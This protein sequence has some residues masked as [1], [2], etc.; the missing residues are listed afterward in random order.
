MVSVHEDQRQSRTVES[1]TTGFRTASLMVC[2]M[3][4]Y[5]AGWIAWSTP[6]RS[7]SSAQC[8]EA[9]SWTDPPPATPL[10]D[11]CSASG[12]I[13]DKDFYALSWQ[14]F[15]FLVW[16]ASDQRGKPDANKKITDEGPR[17]FESLKADWE[18]F[19]PDASQPADWNVYPPTAEPCSND[20]ALKPGTLVLASF[21]K[22][23]S[24]R[25][26][27]EP[28]LGNFLIAQNQTY[29]RYG[30]GYNE[31][32]FRKIKDGGFFKTDV[33]SQIPDAPLGNDI[34]PPGKLEPG[35]LTVKSAWVE[36]PEG[37][38]NY[39]DPSR[40][41]VRQDALIQD[42]ESQE[43]R[44]CRVA[45]V[46]LVGLHIVYKTPSRPQ[47]VWSTFEHV[48]NVPDP[49]AT[50]SLGARFTFN[51]GNP[52]HHMSVRPEPDFQIPKPVDAN[53]PGQ[54]PRAFQVERL[55]HI[56]QEAQ[57]ANGV[58]QAQLGSLGSVW[59]N[60]KLVMTQWPVFPYSPA[61]GADASK[62]SCGMR[63]STATV[64]TTM[65]TF[66]QTSPPPSCL[67][68]R[69]CMGCHAQIARKTDYVVSILLKPHQLPNAPALPAS[70]D[71]RAVAI[72][73]LQDLLE[74]SK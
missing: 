31:T 9:M 44:P 13:K 11:V 14:L 42:P 68:F 33:V 3:A 18:I 19:L 61:M 17:T 34:S 6:G 58:Q 37:G 23:G 53:G 15:K 60:Y 50:P 41:Y 51:D 36:L 27:L 55:Q 63:N 4:L 59:K 54:P 43:K 70:V 57:T 32:V 39:I 72:K 29:V 26:V 46:G 16:P 56:E 5:G 66:H 64:N 20:P 24:L 40:F 49:T 7:Q 47:W 52:D 30:V 65:E 73:Q 67:V 69:T 28:G 62:P 45:R 22:F 12:I 25:E 8:V 10:A 74:R 71:A 48:D 2:A 35:A 21:N 38:P 1:G